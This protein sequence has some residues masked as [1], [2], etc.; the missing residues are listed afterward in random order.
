MNRICFLRI[1]V[2]AIKAHSGARDQRY[3]LEA[4]LLRRVARHAALWY[5]AA[6]TFL[7]KH[8]LKRQF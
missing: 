3:A 6:L 7:P 2:C 1:V 5:D 8:I 4:H